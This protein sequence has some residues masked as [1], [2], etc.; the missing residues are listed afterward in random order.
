[1]WICGRRTASGAAAVA[2]AVALAGC[3]GGGHARAPTPR[4]V[5]I[6]EAC[7]QD[8]PSAAA[9]VGGLVD[10]KTYMKSEDPA[11]RLTFAKSGVARKV[12]S[13]IR[14][15]EETSGPA[16]ATSAGRSFFDALDSLESWLKAPA[17]VPSAVIG[18]R[19]VSTIETAARGVGCTL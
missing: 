7:K 17:A 9:V 6:A 8:K 12:A 3:G 4:K 14:T 16:A 5:S 18:N 11:F 15:L 2:I 1:V 10:Y 19:N 13:A